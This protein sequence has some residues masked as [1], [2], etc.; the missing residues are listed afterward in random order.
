MTSFLILLSLILSLIP[1]FI[2]SVLEYKYHEYR[3]QTWLF[4]FKEKSL[5]FLFLN[6]AVNPFLTTLRIDELRQS[7]KIVLHFETA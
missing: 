2:A 4:A 7:L 3:K 5:L 1:Y 6:S